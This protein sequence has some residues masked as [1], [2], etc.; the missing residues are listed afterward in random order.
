MRIILCAFL[1]CSINA[2]AQYPSLSDYVIG[3]IQ[4]TDFEYKN[5]FLNQS[6]Y[7]NQKKIKT[8]V[9]PWIIPGGWRSYFFV[10]GRQ[11][12][13]WS[14]PKSVIDNST[15]DLKN[16]AV[17]PYNAT[18]PYIKEWSYSS[19]SHI[20]NWKRNYHGIYSANYINHPVQGPVS[21]GFCH[22]ENKNEVEGSCTSGIKYQNTIQQNVLINCN[23]HQ[24]WSGGNPYE[25]GWD[26]YNAI[27]S[28]VWTPNNSQ[29]NWGQGFFNNE[30]GPIVWPNNGYITPGGVKCTTGFR[31]PS[32]I[33]YN[34]YV[35]VFVVQAGSYNGYITEEEGRKGG[36]KILRVPIDQALNASS[37]AIYYKDPLGNVIWNPSLPSGLTKENMLDYVAVKGPKSSDILN[38]NGSTVDVARFSVAKVRNKNYFIGVE[39]YHNWSDPTYK[40]VIRF[41]DDLLNWSGRQIVY[42]GHTW[43]TSQLNYPIF[44]DNSGWSNTEIDEDDFYILGSEHS[45]IEHVNKM[46]IYKYVP[47][48]P[49]PPPGGGE[50]PPDVICEVSA[51]RNLTKEIERSFNEL[52]IMLLTNPV[53]QNAVV[54]INISHTSKLTVNLYNSEGRKMA[55][56]MEETLD[57][58]S[59]KTFDL[60]RFPKGFYI[61]EFISNDGNRIFKKL[62]K[63]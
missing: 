22:G 52:G 55:K 6:C 2:V 39:E 15:I 63:Q 7:D 20:N 42:S 11:T 51:R 41:S 26:A 38:D 21:L 31:H 54:R 13:I 60:S 36:V 1:L 27:L 59:R 19:S 33:I 56:L 12:Y 5:C 10:D 40:V 8:E 35:Y 4:K 37:Y 30:L 24:T 14:S 43:E 29:T 45:P 46:H 17:G 61:L 58:N 34:G 57:A 16:D 48:P 62:I 53:L 23:E 28:A 47:P 3:G 32:S 18:K 9:P 25:D 49:P 44:L 50:C